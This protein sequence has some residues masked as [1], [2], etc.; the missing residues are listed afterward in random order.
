MY[1]SV[2]GI[3]PGTCCT[4]T[5]STI[6]NA[7]PQ[8]QQ[9][10][11]TILGVFMALLLSSSVLFP[12]VCH[13]LHC[14]SRRKSFA[15]ERGY[16]MH[17]QKSPACFDFVRQEATQVFR[18]RKCMHIY[19]PMTPWC[20]VPKKASV[21]QCEIVNNTANVMPATN[22]SM[23]RIQRVN[24]ANVMPATNSGISL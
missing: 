5:R 12:L 7:Q 17:F 3:I 1:K 6:E 10:H 16:T 21:L 23:E 24:T 14:M 2:Q 18:N 20:Q 15:N 13:N 19:L 9:Q 8:C 4:C 22:S 11:P